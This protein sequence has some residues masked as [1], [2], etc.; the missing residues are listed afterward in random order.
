[1]SAD[2]VLAPV[3]DGADVDARSLHVAPSPFGLIERLVAERD[4]LSRQA[5]VVGAE[6]ELAVEVRLGGEGGLVDTQLA[7]GG[8]TQEA[9]EDRAVSSRR[10]NAIS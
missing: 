3:V 7:R 10:S 8:A 9:L 2:A 1:M 4:V 6:Q 5:L